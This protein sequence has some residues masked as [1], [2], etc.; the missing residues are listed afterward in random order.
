MLDDLQA[1]AKAEARIVLIFEDGFKRLEDQFLILFGNANPRV[2]DFK[3]NIIWLT[4]NAD[5]D[6][7]PSR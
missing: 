5:G 6:I 7:V 1:D 3:H 2:A 4:R